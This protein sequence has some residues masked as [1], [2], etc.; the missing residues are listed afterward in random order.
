LNYSKF[1]QLISDFLIDSESLWLRIINWIIAD[2][3]KLQG[4]SP[5]P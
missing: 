3:D 4:L 2:A 5:P 1:V